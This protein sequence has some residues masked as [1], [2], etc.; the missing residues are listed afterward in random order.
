MLVE[1]KIETISQQNV[2][3]LQNALLFAVGTIKMPSNT[4]Q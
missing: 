1:H 2:I 4:Q 3:S